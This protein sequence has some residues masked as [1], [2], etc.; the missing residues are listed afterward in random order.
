M[1]NPKTF[2]DKLAYSKIYDQSNIKTILADKIA[3]KEYVKNQ[4]GSKYLIETICST[5]SIESIDFNE[6]P[7]SFIIKASHGSGW[8]II[9]KDKNK[10]NKKDVLDKCMQFLSMNYYY[11]GREY[12]Y[13]NMNPRIII[14]E[15]LLD[16]EK[17]LPVDY[18]FFS[19]NGCAKFIQVDIDRETKHKRVLF[20]DNWVR[21]P[22][23]YEFPLY[24]LEV[25]KPIKLKEMKDLV[26]VLTK[27][28]KFARVDL[29]FINDRIYIGEITFTPGGNMENFKPKK[30]DYIFGDYYNINC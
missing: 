10:V 19:F 20:D 4:I 13:Y 9:V 16:S 27:D 15:L 14:E 12:Q 21:I 11:F 17:K 26:H 22:V 25:K 6:L 30:Y 5:S 28:M 29:Y 7:N 18:K 3:L 23:E 24:E 1:K 8:N 2:N